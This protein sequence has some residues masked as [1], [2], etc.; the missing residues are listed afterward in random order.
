MHWLAGLLEGEGSFMKG[1]PSKPR[2]SCVSIQMKDED[3]I[4]KVAS[5]FNVKYCICKPKQPHHSVTFKTMLRG[6][7]AIALMVTLRPLMSK[8]R[9][10]QIDRAISQ[11]S[12]W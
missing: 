9:V 11:T 1:P 5:F 6:S 8:R 4:A 12:T 10:E 2:M 3:V 7:K